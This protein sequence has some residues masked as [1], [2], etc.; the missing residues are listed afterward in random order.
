MKCTYLNN[1]FFFLHCT[2]VKFFLK[3]LKINLH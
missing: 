1:C 3:V 2:S